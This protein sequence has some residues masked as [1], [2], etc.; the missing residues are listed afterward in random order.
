MVHFRKQDGGCKLRR[1]QKQLKHMQA[2]TSR[3]SIS[4]IT[5]EQILI[6]CQ[7]ATTSKKKSKLT[8]HTNKY[9]DYHIPLTLHMLRYWSN[10]TF[11]NWHTMVLSVSHTL[12]SSSLPASSSLLRGSSSSYNKWVGHVVT[13]KIP[14]GTIIILPAYSIFAHRNFALKDFKDVA[15]T[16]L[17]TKHSF[18]YHPSLD[19]HPFLTPSTSSSTSLSDDSSDSSLLLSP[20]GPSNCVI[21]LDPVDWGPD[22]VSCLLCVECF[23]PLLLDKGRGPSLWGTLLEVSY[24]SIGNDTRPDTT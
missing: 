17:Y 11:S 24:M 10:G 13:E 6:N 23:L 19:P 12:S 8:K 2:T 1:A 7:Q 15:N 5:K 16:Q 20:L 22:P 3:K 18:A 4:A 14:A 9:D 21:F